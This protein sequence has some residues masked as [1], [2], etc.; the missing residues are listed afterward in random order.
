M[1]YG[2]AQSLRVRCA[3]ALMPYMHGKRPVQVDLTASGDF[4]LIIPG[5]NVPIEDAAAAAAGE[6]VLEAEYLDVDDEAK[7]GK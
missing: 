7:D 5:V 3:E 1:T 2:D 6:F 4:N